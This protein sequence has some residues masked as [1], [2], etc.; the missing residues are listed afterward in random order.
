MWM[1][2]DE[3]TRK[4]TR[5]PLE[6]S[7]TTQNYNIFFNI[8][9]S[10][11]IQKWTNKKNSKRRKRKNTSEYSTHTQPSFT[12]NQKERNNENTFYMLA[13][14]ADT[15][16]SENIIYCLMCSNSRNRYGT[17]RFVSLGREREKI[18]F[19]PF[20]RVDDHHHGGVCGIRVF[21]QWHRMLSRG[22]CS[23]TNHIK[24][25]KRKN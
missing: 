5:Q 2:I 1:D 20:L 8:C 3:T 11:W 21:Q 19:S 9:L 25:K 23:K 12:P 15:C 18:F 22:L 17:F 14:H 16:I 4:Q 6:N 7:T 10:D 24:P 13:Q